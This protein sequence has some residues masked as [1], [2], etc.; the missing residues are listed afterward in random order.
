MGQPE[1]QAPVIQQS[2]EQNA[3][4]Q[5]FYE[6]LTPEQRAQFYKNVL[7]EVLPVGLVNLGNTCYLNST[8][9]VLHQI[10]ELKQTVNN[11]TVAVPGVQGHLVK[12]M[13]SL[14]NQLENAGE[15]IEPRQFLLAF[16]AA[17]PQFA[18]RD[19][20]MKSYR[21][22]DADECFQALLTEIEP[23]FKSNAGDIIR[24]LFEIQFKITTQNKESSEEEPTITF[25]NAR[26]LTCIIDNQMNPVNNL[27]EGIK[28][29]LEDTITKFSESLSRNADFFRRAQLLTLPPYLLVQKIRFVWR[30]KDAGTNTEARKAK[31]LRN[32]AYPKI[33]DVFDF[34]A[35]ELKEQLVP[36]RALEAEQVEQEKKDAQ[37]AYETYKKENQKEGEDNYKLYR[38]FKEEQKRKEDLMHD[39]RLWGEHSVGKVTGNY[40]LVGVITH[41]GRSSDSGHYVA[42]L[43]HKGDTWMKYDDDEVTKV[44]IDDVM[45]LRGGG[46]WHMAYYLM[47][48]RLDF[49]PN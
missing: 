47:Y 11:T 26:K 7:K 13:K 19:E 20:D 17:F 4:K 8:M 12:Q 30:D 28:V 42:W 24:K 29:A 40:E 32:V 46:D 9:Q 45:N 21:Q 38:A 48:R 37:E 5:V 33:L 43:Q 22:Q 18:E 3:G 39:K 10:P 34:C 49:Y 25:E 36:N 23:M 14:F 6:D 41:K 2:L 27:N 1:T 44:G 31:I 35:D 16:F 15:A